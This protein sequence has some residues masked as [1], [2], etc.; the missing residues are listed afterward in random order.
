MDE[1]SEQTDYDLY[2]SLIFILLLI[3]IIVFLFFKFFNSWFELVF[4]NYTLPYQKFGNDWEAKMSQRVE[5]IIFVKS[6][7]TS[8]YIL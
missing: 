4:S 8:S 1:T 6:I 7:T 2:C 5:A 3:I